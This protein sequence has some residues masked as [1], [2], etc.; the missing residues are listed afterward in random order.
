MRVRAK[1]PAR[2][3][4]QQRCLGTLVHLAAAPVHHAAIVLPA[5]RSR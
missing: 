2:K 4:P 1:A 5:T 3:M